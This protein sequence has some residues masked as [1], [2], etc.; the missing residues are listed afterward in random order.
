[1]RYRVI[2]LDLDGTLLTP[3]KTILPESIDALAKAREAGVKI[4]I[5]TGRHHCAIHPF[6]Q[7]L[8]LDT[9]VICC[10]GVY[11]YDYQSKKV[12]EADSLP[13]EQAKQV[14][15]LLDEHHIHGLLYVDDAILYQQPTASILSTLNW[16]Q[17]LP[18]AQRPLFIQVNDLTLA[19]EQ[20]DDIWK[21]A[22]SHPDTQALQHFSNVVEHEM[23]LT[24]VWS[25]NDQVDIARA[26]TSKGKR[27]A[28]WVASQGMQM[29]EVLA[30]GD[31]YNDLSM[32][33]KA[34]LGVAMGNADD[35]IKARA[36]QVIGCNQQPSIARTIFEEVL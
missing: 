35:A 20:A 25:W 14:I 27:L 28:A 2:A 12:L 23:G 33:E 11:L 4:L 31:N 3:E 29:S 13:V 16:A 18:E 34:G 1:M 10:N 5:V 6:Y 24:C 26:G 19:A 30:F 8:E 17:T 9:P 22:L 7:A 36:A 15:S 21:F 32:L